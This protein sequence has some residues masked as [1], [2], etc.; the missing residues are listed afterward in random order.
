MLFQIHKI[1]GVV[2]ALYIIIMS[3]SG[4]ALVFHD[5]LSDFL[6]ATPK[7]VV[8]EAKATLSQIIE[9]TEQFFPNHKV[10]GL[11]FSP[12]AE[13]AIDVFAS[14]E[15]GKFI[16]CLADP[17]TGKILG[18]KQTN[19]VLQFLRDL[20][21]NL[22]TGSTGRTANGVGASCLLLLAVTGV[23]VSL[24]RYSKALFTMLKNTF[25]PEKLIARNLHITVGI[26]ALPFLIFQS[27]GGVYFG[28]PAVF[29]RCLNCIAPVSALKGAKELP[30]NAEKLESKE[31]INNSAKSQI[32]QIVLKAKSCSAKPAFVERIAF[33]NKKSSAV[34]I[35]LR[36]SSSHD[37]SA[38]K[39][40]VFLSPTTG[41]V[42]ALSTPESTPAGDTI[43]QWL[44][45]F[46]FG[47]LFGILSKCAWLVIGL[48]P[49]VLAVT[50][51]QML[52]NKSN[53]KRK[54]KK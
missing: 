27:I 33:P 44:L 26:C 25:R 37:A 15:E 36:D 18:L 20:H 10:T 38:P 49:A 31:H 51:L 4:V 42:L 9:N 39:T 41:E 48:T 7:V 23:A 1:F 3:L 8:Q 50:G 34:Q 16:Q 17:Y 54:K 2:S 40:K 53:A 29:Q 46:H 28:F 12:D 24:Q 14:K 47:K 43:I 22:L 11:I 52:I 32:D 35:W 6:C 30:A 13:R 5:D 19:A 45:D 21:F